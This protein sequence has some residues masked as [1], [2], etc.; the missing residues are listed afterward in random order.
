MALEKLMEAVQSRNS[1][2]TIVIAHAVDAS[3]FLA[4]KQAL[5]RNLASFILV[6]PLKE[7]EK[8]LEEAEIPKELEGKVAKVNAEDDKASA[9]KAVQLVSEGKGNAL[10][11]GMLSTSTL[12]K[13]VLNKEVGL[14]TGKVLSHLAGF[15]FADKEQLLFLTDA[16]MN[17]APDLR[18]KEQIIENAVDA[19]RHIGIEKPRVAVIT[20]V[21]TVNPAMQATLDAAAL[22]QMNR[23]GQLKNCIVDGPLGLDNAISEESAKQKGITSEVAGKADILLAPSIEAG[24]VLYKSLTYFGNAVVGGII[25]GA[26]APIILT[27]RTDKVESKLLSMLL[28][29]SSIEA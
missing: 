19:V 28:A 18:D 24:N 22:T 29:I 17:I 10:M 25:V 6:G 2:R 11:K 5:E 16:A 12:L 3:L 1:N 26:K 21:E 27:S 9:L 15:S 8:L 7:M 14:R 20:A 23:R 4:M 13:A